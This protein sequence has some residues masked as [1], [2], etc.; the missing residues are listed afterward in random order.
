[1]FRDAPNRRDEGCESSSGDE[2]PNCERGGAG[3]FGSDCLSQLATLLASMAAAQAVANATKKKR[4]A[5]RARAG[6]RA[7]L[8]R[9]S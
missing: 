7:Q 4:R 2:G 8:A 6:G 9:D 3:A 5:L 1:M